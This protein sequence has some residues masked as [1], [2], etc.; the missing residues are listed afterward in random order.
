VGKNNLNRTVLA[1]GILFLF[2]A[3]TVTPAVIS[4][5][6]P[7]EDDDYLENLAF[8]CYD[9]YGSNSNYEYYKEHLLNNYSNTE[10]DVVEAVEPVVSSTVAMS[11]G[12]MDSAWPMFGHDTRNTG[13][14][15]FSTEN[16]TGIEKWRYDID[17]SVWF[18]S[19]VIDEDGVI[20]I[21]NDNLHAINPDGTLKWMYDHSF[22]IESTPVLDDNDIIYAAT[23]N[24]MNNILYAIYTSNGTLKWS[25]TIVGDCKSSPTV[26]TDGTIYVS[27]GDDL[28]AIYSNGTR[29]WR[30]H[31]GGTV[32][33]SPAIDEESIYFGSHDFNVYGLW[34]D[35]GTVKWTF[36][37]DAWVHGA[38]SIGVDGTIYIGSDDG[39][40]YALYPNNGTLKWKTDVGPMWAAPAIDDEGSLYFGVCDEKFIAVYPNGEIKWVFDLGD[41]NGVWASSAA[42]SADGTIYFGNSIRINYPN[43]GE[44]IA[45]DLDGNLKWRKTIATSLIYSSP[46]IGPDGTVYIPSTSF[47][48]YTSEGYLHAFGPVDSNE[49]PSTPTIDGPLEG[50]VGEVYT[51][52]VSSNDPDNN[53]VGFY[54]DWGDGTNEW[55]MDYEQGLEIPINHE[56]EEQDTYTIAVKARDSVGEESDWAYLEVK[57]PVDQQYPFPLLQRFSE[58]FPNMFP[59]LRHLL[60]AQ[61]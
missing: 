59:I 51:Y 14:S 36:E 42:I 7:K 1:V 22:N 23:G 50:Q 9:E 44:I 45:L 4:Y 39:F 3:S 35:T 38:P 27:A 40:L 17:Y 58:R 20:Y 55:T 41:Y 24:A 10:L 46:A 33:S 2:I 16:I 11:S 28:V 37:T 34:K 52:Y 60:E 26:D 53:P 25:Y 48:P 43:G 54:V 57:M 56:W 15:S 19:P 32:Y 13:R 30:F 47:N 29:K 18:S 21:G 31:T 8:V 49:P 5:D 6:E 61:Y 12:P